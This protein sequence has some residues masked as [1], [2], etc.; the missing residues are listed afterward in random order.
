[1]DGATRG[2]RGWAEGVALVSAARAT[3]AERGRAL[4]TRQALACVER[5]WPAGRSIAHGD[6]RL[7]ALALALGGRLSDEPAAL[8]RRVWEALRDGRAL[9]L[10]ERPVLRLG[11]ATRPTEAPSEGPPVEERLDDLRLV[12]VEDETWRPV[13]G[14]DLT[15]LPSTSG[16]VQRATDGEGAVDVRRIRPGTF[17]VRAAFEGATLATCYEVVAVDVGE[18]PSPDASHREALATGR[19]FAV[20]LRRHKVATGE[21]LVSVASAH[22]MTWQQLARFNFGSAAPREV[23]RGL[24][25]QV[26]CRTKT[27]DRANYV[28]S[29]DDAPGVLFIPQAWEQRGLRTG[30]T[31]TVRLRVPRVE[32][33]RRFIFSL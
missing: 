20:S 3:V 10:W 23:N 14:I 30:G 8:R 19:R 31:H 12:A 22:G 27:A 4:S 25:H 15:I 32:R 7:V 9:A 16:P 28:F 29:D 11:G 2:E 13:R 26:G 5:A 24:R 33:L 1:M 18:A 6:G 21:T 17:A